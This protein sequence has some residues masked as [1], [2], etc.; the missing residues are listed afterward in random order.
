[1]KH[2]DQVISQALILCEPQSKDSM[3]LHKIAQHV[4]DLIDKSITT[5]DDDR[6]LGLSVGGS[7]AKGTWLTED[8]DIDFFVKINPNVNKR[9]FE[10]LGTRIGLSALSKYRPYLRYSDHPYVEAKIQKVR[11]NIVPCYQVN[12]GQWKSAADRSPFHTQY[13]NNNLDEEKRKQVRLL[14]KFLK[15]VGV[16]G[17][18]IA[19]SGFSGYVAEIL[20]LKYGSFQSALQ[21]LSNISGEKNVISIGKADQDIIDSFQGPIVI[22]DPI[23]PNRNL[24]AAISTE[25]ISKLVLAAR[26]FLA[27]PSLD[28]FREK[29]KKSAKVSKKLYANLLIVEFSYLKRSPDVIWGQLKRILSA[30]SKQLNLAD[31]RVI[32]SV[33]ITDEE[34][35][36]ALVFLLESITLPAYAEK[37]GPEIFRRNATANFISKNKKESLLMWIDREMKVKS[38]VKRK[39][40]NAKDYLI[41]LLTKKIESTGIKTKPIEGISGPLLI[42][43]GDERK[44][45][46]LVKN[47]VYKLVTTESNI[48]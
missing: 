32:R 22:I 19:T 34:N 16:Y 2:I 48:F 41:S 37:I 39:A 26:A 44:I 38:L 3:K 30:M 12:R 5:I 24:G 17:A 4:T 11:I 28:F 27:K 7:Y 23:D 13:I 42:Y 15:S 36:A 47:A 25:S 31:F 8:N 35:S 40:T 9:E 33:C 6:I 20:I 29:E 14:K 21:A 1:M 46:G 43:T 10:Q 45:G 18:E